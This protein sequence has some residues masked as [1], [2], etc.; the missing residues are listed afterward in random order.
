MTA[1]APGRAQLARRAGV[2]S[3]AVLASRVL[4]LVREQVF[5]VSFDARTPMRVSVF[6]I[7]VNYALNWLFVRVLG[8][9]ATG[10]ALSTSLVALANCVIL[11]VLLRRRLGA[12]G[13]G[14]GVALARIAVATALM[15]VAAVAVDA[16]VVGWLPSRPPAHHGLR[17]ALVVRAGVAAFWVACRSLG[18][19]VPVVRRRVSP[20]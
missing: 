17:V 19:P 9:G 3:A 11:L 5:A 14:L 4:G 18:I 20:T 15:L 7:A 6:S 8:F 1:D 12:L 16:T 10:L 13:P 2:V